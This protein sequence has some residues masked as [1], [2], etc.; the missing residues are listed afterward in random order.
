MINEEIRNRLKISVYAFAYEIKHDSLI[1]DYEYDL[2]AKK[3]NVN[4]S[5]NNKLL[6]EFFRDCYTP[7]SGMWVTKHPELGKLNKLY[8]KIIRLT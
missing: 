7:D 2:L 6:D 5:T 8:E 4:V 1:S 3:I